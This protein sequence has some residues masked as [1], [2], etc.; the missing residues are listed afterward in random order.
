MAMWPYILLSAV[1]LV[2]VGAPLLLY[3]KWRR[4]WDFTHQGHRIRLKGGVVPGPDVLPQVVRAIELID[5]RFPGLKPWH[6]EIT[7]RGEIRTPTVRR[8]VLKDGTEVGGSV[9][10][11]WGRW[12]AVVVVERTGQFIIHEVAW[13][14]QSLK[15]RGHPDALHR[16]EFLRDA[17]EELQ[18]KMQKWVDERTEPR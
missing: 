1:L 2:A 16:S 4:S 7:K 8:G 17:T 11:E 10:K 14:I 9:R 13:H 3:L 12:V 15:T 6:I 5:N 18:K